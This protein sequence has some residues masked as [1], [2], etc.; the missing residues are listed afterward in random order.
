MI[1]ATTQLL[2]R[3]NDYEIQLQHQLQTQTQ[4]QT[5]FLH[6]KFPNKSLAL[7][8]TKTGILAG[9]TITDD[10][11]TIH[12]RAF[13]V[14]PL[15]S[16]EKTKTTHSEKAQL[17]FYHLSKQLDYLIIKEHKSFFQ[18]NPEN[19]IIIDG[20]RIA[21]IDSNHDHLLEIDRKNDTLQI[22]HLFTR[23][24]WD[25]PELNE[26]TALPA[27]NIHYKTIYYTLAVATL[28]ILFSYRNLDVEEIKTSLNKIKDSKL[29]YTLERCLQQ[30]PNQRTILYL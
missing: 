29:F 25:S 14:T 8:L 16:C 23:N 1:N 15:F 17:F 4:T 21:Y 5:F 3:T 2:Y 12:F 28:S 22:L 7:S 19:F 6:W 11:Q 20:V 30:D 9:G 10:Y 13:S 27:N 24:Q 18:L 26:I